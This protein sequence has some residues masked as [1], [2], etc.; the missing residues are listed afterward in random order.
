MNNEED[1]PA[2]DTSVT[3]EWNETIDETGTIRRPVS[4]YLFS[5]QRINPP[6]T[7]KTIELPSDTRSYTIQNLEPETNY[8][9][10][11]RALNPL[12]Q[13][14]PLIMSV[15]TDQA[16]IPST[17]TTTPVPNSNPTVLPNPGSTTRVTSRARR[18]ADPDPPEEFDAVHGRHGIVAYWDNPRWDGGTDILAYSVDWYPEPPTFPIFV[19]PTK[20]S[21]LIPGMKSGVNYRVRVRAFNRRDDSM[22]A[23]QR[24]ELHDTLVRF[25]NYDPLTGSIANGRSTVLQNET[26]LPGFEIQADSQSMFWGDQM[27]LAVKR[28]SMPDRSENY[29]IGNGFEIVSDVFEITPRIESRRKRFDNKATTYKFSN[30]I[31]ICISYSTDSSDALTN[32]SV[33]KL[34]VGREH[35]VEAIFDSVQID[36]NGLTKTCAD[37]SELAINEINSF[38][39]VMNSPSDIHGIVG[40]DKRRP[41]SAFASSLFLFVVGPLLILAGSKLLNRTSRAAAG[42][43]PDESPATCSAPMT[44]YS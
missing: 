37:V 6:G 18:N 13:S 12:G 4:S 41:R 20:R 24:I 19:P 25:R 17:P 3:I 36:G 29:K 42:S 35:Q 8:E 26:E 14:E 33:A 2:T 22:P 21:T 9:I 23:A 28:I 39:A 11:L 34:A 16:P 31:R 7:A 15:T 32:F 1:V 40:N 5:W 30:S 43:T 27:F 38:V 44:D 10:A